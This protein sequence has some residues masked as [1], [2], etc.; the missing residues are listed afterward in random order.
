MLH[1]G[2]PIGAVVESLCGNCSAGRAAQALMLQRLADAA[3]TLPARRRLLEHWL[4]TFEHAQRHGSQWR[5]IGPGTFVGHQH[6]P[7]E[8]TERFDP[9]TG[10]VF[11]RRK[12]RYTPAARAGGLAARSGRSPRQLHRYRGSLR[13]ALLM[14]SKQPPHDARDAQRSAGGQWAYAQ[15]WL[16]FAPPPALLAR[17]AGSKRKP[18]VRRTRPA[19][20]AYT[21]AQPPRAD[22]LRMLAAYA[23]R[24]D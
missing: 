20:R 3:P 14:C 8:V 6:G 17:W 4:R 15:H 16:P 7:L 13:T 22:D 5:A 19:A 1:R 12:R 11:H 18:K 2:E 24:E 9:E 21:A 23:E 10:E